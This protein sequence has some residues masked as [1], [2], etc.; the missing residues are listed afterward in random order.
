[1]KNLLPLA[2]VP[3]SF[4]AAAHPGHVGVHLEDAGYLLVGA[5]LVAGTW[6]LRFGLRLMARRGGRFP[7]RR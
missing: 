7:R 5:A 3:A 1:M 4:P 6:L 2:L